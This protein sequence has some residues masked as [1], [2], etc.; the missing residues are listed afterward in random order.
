ML[1]KQIDI[2][3]DDTNIAQFATMDV[4]GLWKFNYCK[5]IKRRFPNAKERDENKIIRVYNKVYEEV[6]NG[7]DLF[8]CSRCGIPD[9]K[10][11]LDRGVEHPRYRC[12]E[13]SFFYK[14]FNSLSKECQNDPVKHYTELSDE[15]SV[16]F[17][18]IHLLSSNV[19]IRYQ[20]S[21]W[22]RE[23]IIP[24]YEGNNMVP[25]SWKMK[26]WIANEKYKN[27]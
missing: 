1:V 4:N 18:D 2:N 27:S 6:L 3:P 23:F 5:Y 25:F 13:E 22:C 17:Q 7:P 20:A 12:E 8:I 14:L 26:Y 15:H 21:D 9:T 24:Y 10:A 11:N 19:A 16:K